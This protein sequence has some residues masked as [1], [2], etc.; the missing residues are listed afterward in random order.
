[1]GEKTQ[2]RDYE[3]F[4]VWQ[5]SMELPKE[6]YELTLSFPSEEKYGTDIADAK[7]SRVRTLEYC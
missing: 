4:R 6:I 2:I 5:K 7:G 1:M 3:D